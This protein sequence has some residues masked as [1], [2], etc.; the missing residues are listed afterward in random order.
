VDALAVRIAELGAFVPP[1]WYAEVTN[2]LLQAH[3]RGRITAKDVTQALTRIR[4][5]NVIDSPYTSD[6]G[7]LAEL[8]MK[9]G[10]TSYDALYLDQAVAL[11]AALATLDTDLRT[12]ASAAGVQLLPENLKKLHT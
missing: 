2:V 7:R 8:G 1:L 6:I 3:K 5:L 10:L 11:G 12:A 9:Y 4:R